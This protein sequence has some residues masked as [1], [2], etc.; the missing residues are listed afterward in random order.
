[1]KVSVITVCYNAVSTIEASILSL[2]SQDYENLE[3]IVIDGGSSDGTIDIIKRYLPH[4]YFFISGPDQGIYDAIN[5]GI[6][7]ATGE[8]I[9]LLH[10]NDRF[11]S[12][13]V[14][15]KVAQ[16]MQEKEADA[17]YGNLIFC[18]AEGKVVRSWISLPSNRLLLELGW[19]PPHPTLYIRKKIFLQYGNYRL[20]FSTAADYE[21]I[22]R[23]FY[24]YRIKTWHVDQVF[25]KMLTGGI[26]N[27]SIL[28][29]VTGNRNDFKA[30]KKHQLRAPFIAVFL[31]PLQKLIQYF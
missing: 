19:M 30:M 28:N 21:L 23:F 5:K 13:H 26:S 20:D 15:S 17:V 8:V 1:M 6:A 31:K 22:L 3:Y 2:L 25:I 18:N 4:I 24:R 14:I 7:Q 16:V 10:A 27:K 9:G 29:H 11:Y 12:N